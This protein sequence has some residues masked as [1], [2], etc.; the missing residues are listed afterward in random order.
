MNFETINVQYINVPSAN[1][2]KDNEVIDAGHYTAFSVELPS[3]AQVD[4]ATYNLYLTDI[5]MT[6]N[7]KSQYLKWALYDNSNNP[8]I[9]N[10]EPIQ[11]DFSMA[12][13]LYNCTT[14]DGYNLCN[15]ENVILY[16]TSINKGNV[17]SY[18]L[19]LWL[20]YDE[21]VLQNDLLKGSL[22][23]KVGFKGITNTSE[24]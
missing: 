14:K 16:N 20:S 22:E 19:Y 2:I 17:H 3:D 10:G 5:K 6:T 9:V 12:K 8:I 24:N 18:R 15:F 4:S 13:N 1:L 11:G 21:D 7:F 23:A